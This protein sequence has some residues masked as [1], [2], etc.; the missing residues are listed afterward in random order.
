M[1]ENKPHSCEPWLAQTDLFV[2]REGGYHTYRIPALTASPRG[3]LLAFCEGRR[4]S[5]ADYGEIDILLRRSTDGGNTWLPPQVIAT[6]LATTCGNPC[7]VVDGDR[8]AI[9]LVFCKNMA[10]GDEGL[11]LEG[12]A[13]RT[14]WVTRSDDDGV[15]WSPPTEITLSA[16]NPNWTWYDTGP[17]HGI[18][19][20]NGRLLLACH[21]VGGVNYNARDPRRSHVIYSDDHGDHWNL[22]GIIGDNTK[23]G[24][25]LQTAY[26][27]IYLNCRTTNNSGKR[28]RAL[29]LDNGR[30]FGLPQ[31]DNTLLDPVEGL[32][33]HASVI[34]LTAPPTHSRNRVLFANPA[35]HA[36]RERMTVRISYDEARTWNAGK[37]LFPG[38]SAFCDLAVLPD[39]TICCVYENGQKDAYEKLTLARFNLEWLT[40][41]QDHIG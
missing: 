25:V 29:S 32:G 5:S 6:E 2:G 8:G 9:H 24:T 34:R 36:R 20:K 31:A 14:V 11:V 7:V 41:G 30:S 19:L 33:C 22:G 1:S 4:E 35:S 28:V 10:H 37:I 12:K 39:M 3:S 40:D 13:S 26:G 18:H 15:T 38:H 27:T 16:K 21:H 23:E 17:G